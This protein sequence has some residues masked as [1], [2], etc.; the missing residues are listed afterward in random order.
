MKEIVDTN[1][2][3][4]VFAGDAAVKSYIE[5]LNA[6]IDTTIYIE[7]LQGSKSNQE[8]QKIKRYLYNFPLLQIMPETSEL[9]IELIDNYSNSHG[10]LLADALIAAAAL[11]NHL[12]V[13]TYNLS[14]F[15]FINSLK[16]LR[17]N[18]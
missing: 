5:S 7:C 9:A 14:D 4:K 12:T 18:V 13:V 2:F 10:L 8:K 3:S 16:T 1:V 17:P 15:A 11:E 6:V